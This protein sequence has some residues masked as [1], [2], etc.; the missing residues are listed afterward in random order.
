MTVVEKIKLLAKERAS[1]RGITEAAA[2]GQLLSESPE[3][4]RLAMRERADAGP[5]GTSS[6]IE[7]AKE[8][9]R[10]GALRVLPG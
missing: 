10:R 6:S 3:L 8:A 2:Y 1:E 5:A 4:Y 7:Y 9:R